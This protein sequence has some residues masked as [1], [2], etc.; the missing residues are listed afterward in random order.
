MVL[1]QGGGG[2]VGATARAVDPIDPRATK[3]DDREWIR[4]IR[5][6]SISLDGAYF[7][8]WRCGFRRNSPHRLTGAHQLRLF[9]F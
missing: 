6:A 5:P 4:S 8:G 7:P 2:N 3:H 9:R 1:S